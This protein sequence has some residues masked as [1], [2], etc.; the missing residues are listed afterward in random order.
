MKRKITI[1]IFILLVGSVFARNIDQSDVPAVV[2]NTFQLKFPTAD[3]IKWKLEKDNYQVDYKVNSKGNKLTIDFKGKILKHNQDLFISEIPRMV[4]ETIKKRV[5]YF[6]VNDA[7]KYVEGNKIIY[8]IQ[9]KINGKDYFFWINEKGKLLKFRRELKESEV[10]ASMMQF[11]NNK[12]GSTDYD[13]AKFVEENGNINYIIRVKINKMEH[14]FWMGN[15]GVLLKHI[16]DLR[17]S[18]IPAPVL[19]AANSNYKEYEIHDADWIE[20][21]NSSTYKLELRKSNRRVYLTINPD[22][23]ILDVKK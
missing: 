19:N 22:G 8:E 10:P 1:Y 6:D 5:G 15:N 14:L 18:E 9:F 23:K 3:D 13:R 21:R 16:Q 7:D 4:L 11:I 20:E 2:L 12:Y 17:D